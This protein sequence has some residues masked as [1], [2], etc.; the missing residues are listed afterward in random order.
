MFFSFE[1][2]VVTLRGRRFPAAIVDVCGDRR[3]VTVRVF[4]NRTRR[5]PLRIATLLK[6][7]VRSADYDSDPTPTVDFVL[8]AV[9]DE[10]A[11][12]QVRV[13]RRPVTR[14]PIVTF[15]QPKAGRRA[16]WT[17]RAR[18]IAKGHAV[19]MSSDRH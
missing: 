12:R 17:N 14:W 16:G 1:V 8:N 9:L 13:N 3:G 11:S 5:V 18:R 4:T 10:L 15:D 6:V 19:A 7:D 2:P